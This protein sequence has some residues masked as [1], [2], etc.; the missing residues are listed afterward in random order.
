MTTLAVPFLSAHKLL[1]TYDFKA[2]WQIELKY[3]ETI[4][5]EGPVVPMVTAW[6]GNAPRE[7]IG[8]PEGQ[9]R[10]HDA[11]AKGAGPEFDAF[12]EDLGNF[13]TEP[14]D[15]TYANETIA[16][17]YAEDVFLDVDPPDD[18]LAD[19]EE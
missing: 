11:L 18:D 1:Y 9:Q 3:K 12:K 4:D 7:S 19:S 2:N 14:Y 10:L 13:M 16:A 17:L 15:L 6:K 8:G 5:V